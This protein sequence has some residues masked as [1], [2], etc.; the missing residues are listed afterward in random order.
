MENKYTLEKST[1]SNRDGFDINI[2]NTKKDFERAST[3]LLSVN[4]FH[5]RTKNKTNDRIYYVI[6]GVG[7]F[8]IEDKTISVKSTDVVIIPKNTLYDF[9]GNMKLFLVH[10]PAFDRE[11]EVKDL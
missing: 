6:E 1:E 11:N 9:K 10:T 8:I 3:A 4:G 7:E 5:G 2:Y